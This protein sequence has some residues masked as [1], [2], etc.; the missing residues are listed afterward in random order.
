MLICPQFPSFALST[1]FL[2]L[3]PGTDIVGEHTVPL[4]ASAN[5]QH[6]PHPQNDLGTRHSRHSIPCMP[7][8]FISQ[9]RC[10]WGTNWGSVRRRVNGFTRNCGIESA[11]GSV[12][13]KIDNN[14]R[15]W[16]SKAT[17][18]RLM[19]GREGTRK[20]ELS[21]N[22]GGGSKEKLTTTTK[23]A[24]AAAASRN[25][26]ATTFPS[27]MIADP[28]GGGDGRLTGWLTGWLAG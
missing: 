27:R 8:I 26:F 21:G 13:E 22:C 18:Q 25:A 12:N 7:I 4:F 24:S 19:A 5:M 20:R 11:V 10:G 16:A 23:T 14:R 3:I 2:I 17:T 9:W 6:Y 28:G 1:Q 15:R